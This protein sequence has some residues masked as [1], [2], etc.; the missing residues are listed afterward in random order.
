MVP[1]A[2]DDD[3]IACLVSR[4]DNFLGFVPSVGIEDLQIGRTR[5]GEQHPLHVDYITADD[6]EL[7]ARPGKIC[8]RAASF[9][10]FLSE[11]QKG[12]ETY[13]PYLETPKEDIPFD[14]NKF[15]RPPVVLGGEKGLGLMVRPKKGNAIFW[16]NML[17]N[18]TMDERMLHQG[19]RV[20]EGEKYG[21]NV[22]AEQCWDDNHE[23]KE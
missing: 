18:G 8:N 23:S 11:V 14:E 17:R 15:R 1:V 6:P 7:Y 21:L 20:K 5:P 19:I 22:L 2:T 13:F 4:A 3:I 10:V 12:G 16:M 9:F